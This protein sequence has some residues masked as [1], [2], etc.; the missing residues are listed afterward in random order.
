MNSIQ[1]RVFKQDNVR[2]QTSV[3]TQNALKSVDMLSWPTRSP[4]LSAIE[5]V[6]DIIGQHHPQSAMTVPVLTQQ[7]Q[8]TWN[9]I[10]QSD[11]WF[12]YDTMHARLHSKF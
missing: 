2:P 6:W 3:V 9:S 5:H 4:N 7:V 8:Q 11:I 1:G 12:L 10:S